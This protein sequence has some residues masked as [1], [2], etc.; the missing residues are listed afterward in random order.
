MAPRT[1]KAVEEQPES[2]TQDGCRH[3]R[4]TYGFFGHAEAEHTLLDSYRS[5]TLPSAIILGGPAGI[6]KATLAWRMA[7]FL[8]AYPDPRL[9]QV[10]KAENLFV[11]PDHPVSHQIEA[12]SHPDI[13]IL[14]RSWNEKTK[15]FFT[16][17][18]A[19]E[20]RGAIHLFQQAAGAGGY[21]IC[22]ID[23]AEDLNRSSANALLKTLEEP[24][25][26]SLFLIVSHK[27]DSLLPTIRSR[28]QKLMLK[29]LAPD[30]IADI[31]NDLGAPWSELPQGQ[32]EAA[33]GQAQGSMRDAL[34]LL[35]GGGIAFDRQVRGLLEA[36]PRVDWIAV[37]DLANQVSSPAS[38]PDYEI[39]MVTLLDWIDEKMKSRLELADSPPLRQ[40]AALA[41]VWEKLGEAARETEALNLD[42]RP[43]VLSIFSNLASATNDLA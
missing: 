43:F 14:R 12:L 29:T 25:P 21:R 17:I 28:C 11:S 16:E 36:L 19:E 23:S 13:L 22:I 1:A 24:P 8:L 38:L 32:R 2:D 39:L 37:H 4:D 10:Q 3:P 40:L 34:R 30:D 18:R 31:L 33:A 41:E 42:K 5:G 9:P 27:P 7:R 35:S 6:G 15:K 26:K 20:V